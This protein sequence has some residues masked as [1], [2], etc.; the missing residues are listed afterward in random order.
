MLNTKQ[1]LQLVV[2]K[3]N[4]STCDLR[5]LS[6]IWE[7]F[8]RWCAAQFDAKVGIRVLGMGEFALRKDRLGD[9]EFV[10]P[11]F[12]MDEGYA[13]SFGL[14]D[15]RPKTQSA[16]GESIDVDMLAIASITTDL[17]GEVV[18]KEF[19]EAALA[20]VFERIGLVCGDP[21]TYG[22]VTVDFGFAKLFCENKSLECTFGGAPGK[23]AGAPPGTAASSKSAPA[24]KLPP[25]GR[26]PPTG[27]ST[28]SMGL[29][30]SALLR[31]Q[32]AQSRTQPDAPLQRPHRP[33]N[34][35]VQH[36]SKFTKEELLTSHAKQLTEKE[37]VLSA[38]REEE[39][40]QHLETLQRLRSEMVLDYTQREQRREL[41]K[42]LATHQRVQQDE[43]RERDEFD[44]RVHGMDHWPF[45]TE[46]QVQE[47]ISATNHAQKAYLDKQ[48]S[49]K[50]DKLSFLQQEAAKRQQ[51]EQAQ[52]LDEL[53][54]LNAE[55][56]G[57][58]A[59]PQPKG[60]PPVHGVERALEDAFGRYEDY[61]HT[62]K[63]GI[64]LNSSFQREQRYLSEQAELLKSE[65]QRRRM[66]EMRSY[67]ERQMKEK[68][69]SKAVGKLEARHEARNSPVAALP[70]GSDIDAEEEAYVKMALK[71]ALD[72]Q[73]E[74]KEQTKLVAKATDLKQEQQALG[75]V[76]REMQEARFRIW[77]ERKQ[78]EEALR[79]TW[80]KQ[81]QLKLMEATLDKAEAA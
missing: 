17:L 61:L 72:G 73:V 74:R 39:T 31:R 38:S 8:L 14:H 5:F 37:L 53:R 55:R 65:E 57:G 51:K 77:S 18:T 60:A 78:Q 2:D 43:K 22:I 41:T 64:E 80:A 15:R 45:R 58:R 4:R 76:A 59:G 19:V 63:E 66:G 34:K 49:E 81:Q 54:A 25:I 69:Q 40:G 79:A 10:N 33:H 12:V 48:L 23:A 11:M 42:L 20:D 67:L 70:T 27:A 35:P 28:S 13:R 24:T 1:L 21:D 6:H 68:E 62:R 30:G 50:R 44:R 26:P 3:P 32:Q 56:K 7:A 71:N 75:H 36:C 52:A 47:A 46:E 16:D 9:M 29:D